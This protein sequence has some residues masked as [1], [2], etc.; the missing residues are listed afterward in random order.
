MTE[1]KSCSQRLF[2]LAVPHDGHD[3]AGG[4]HRRFE[5]A[6]E[7]T[8]GQK[9]TSIMACAHQCQYT[10]PTQGSNTDDFANR[11][12]LHKKIRRE[13]GDEIAEKED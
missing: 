9:S 12:F 6:Q 7:E 1:P 8:E 5:H 11:E 2:T 3:G 4:K 13:L 10:A